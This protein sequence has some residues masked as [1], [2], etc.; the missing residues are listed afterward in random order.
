MELQRKQD[1]SLVYWLR[2]LLIDSPFISITSEYREDELTIPRITLETGVTTGDTFELG[3]KNLLVQRR[4]YLNIYA[5]N[6]SQRND[7]A[8]KL[9]NELNT[10]IPV[11]DYDEE[12]LPDELPTQI[13]TFLL[14]DVQITPIEVLPELV[15]TLYWRAVVRYTAIYNSKT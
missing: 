12:T 7:Y 5:I 4:Y 1:A 2:T 10:S 9:F 11:Y 6:I 14:E 13:G 3:N 15:E 8:Y